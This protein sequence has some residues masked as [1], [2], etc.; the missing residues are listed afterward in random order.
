MDDGQL[1]LI[2]FRLDDVRLRELVAANRLDEARARFGDVAAFERVTREIEAA[3]DLDQQIFDD[4][5]DS[6]GAATTITD[7]ALLSSPK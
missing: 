1:D 6:A 4:L 3:Q 2:A 5:T 7:D